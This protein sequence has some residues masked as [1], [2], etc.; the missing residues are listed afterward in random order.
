MPNI[1]ELF[2]HKL[3]ICLYRSLDRYSDLYKKGNFLF[4]HNEGDQ[5]KVVLSLINSMAL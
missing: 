2:K 4:S 1:Q 5:S 3:I